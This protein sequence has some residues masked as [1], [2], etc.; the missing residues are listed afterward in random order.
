MNQNLNV[1]AKIKT[2]KQLNENIGMKPK[3][4]ARGKTDLTSKFFKIV[5]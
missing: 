2:K 3:A 4:Q 1:R 5:L